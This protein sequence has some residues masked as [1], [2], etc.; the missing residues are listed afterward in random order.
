MTT[1]RA[2]A[3]TPNSLRNFERAERNTSTL[4]AISPLPYDY[5]VGISLFS[6]I[7]R[8]FA[9]CTAGNA[10]GNTMPL[11]EDN[12]IEVPFCP[13]QERIALEQQG[14]LGLA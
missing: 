2:R 3:G 5:M 7:V 12:V 8:T 1:P 4:I 11:G 6:G 10:I 9:R 14:N 13:Y